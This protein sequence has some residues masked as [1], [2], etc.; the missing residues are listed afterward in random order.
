MLLSRSVSLPPSL[1]HSLLPPYADV[2]LSA[3]NDSDVTSDLVDMEGPGQVP[4][5]KKLNTFD[6]GL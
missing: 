3:L 2:T 1:T 5:P 4:G 6:Q